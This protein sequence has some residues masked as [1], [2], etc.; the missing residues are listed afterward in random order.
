LLEAVEVAP[1]EVDEEP[2]VNPLWVELSD[3]D[4]EPWD[5]IIPDTR[6][7]PADTKVP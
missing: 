7:L 1:E 2:V 3:E 4:E 6:L 5:E